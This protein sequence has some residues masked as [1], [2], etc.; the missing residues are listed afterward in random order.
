MVKHTK[1]ICR[2]FADELFE[3]IWSFCGIGAERVNKLTSHFLKAAILDINPFQAETVAQVFCK[4]CVLKNFAKFTVKQLCQTEACNFIIKETLA[5]V[6]SCEF[7][8]TFIS[9]F[10]REHLQWLLLFRPFFSFC[11]PWKHQKKR[12]FLFSEG[13]EW[14]K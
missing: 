4:N 7:C 3:C 10:F 1:A 5:Q 14:V 12:G 11:T 9:K 8:E 13:M 6:F 2:Q